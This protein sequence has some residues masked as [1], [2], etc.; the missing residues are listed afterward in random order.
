M[1]SSNG[2]AVANQLVE[3]LTRLAHSKTEK[4]EVEKHSW[5]SA[6]HLNRATWLL[7]IFQLVLIIFYGIFG[8]SEVIP[9]DGAGSGTQAY[10]M[11][12]GVEIMM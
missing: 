1:S 8:G 3:I 4:K 10:N 9:K 11:C 7:G 2:V 12:I 6:K 5:A